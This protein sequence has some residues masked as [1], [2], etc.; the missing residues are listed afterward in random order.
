[1]KIKITYTADDGAAFDILEECLA[2]EMLHSNDTD[3]ESS[4]QK[5]KRIFFA[6]CLMTREGDP[7]PIYAEDLLLNLLSNLEAAMGELS[8]LEHYLETQKAA[9]RKLMNAK[10]KER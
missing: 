10:P 1:M 2:H 3:V 9:A 6:G 8:S 7:A 4:L 5:L